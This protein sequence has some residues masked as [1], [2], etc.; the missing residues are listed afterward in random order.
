M[1]QDGLL[2]VMAELLSYL[3]DPI[4]IL[5]RSRVYEPEEYFESLD[6]WQRAWPDA[7]RELRERR[8]QEYKDKIRTLAAGHEIKDRRFY[9]V[10][11]YWQP[12]LRAM[13]AKGR[14]P[15]VHS[16]AGSN[17]TRLAGRPGAMG[18]PCSSSRR[19]EAELR[20]DLGDDQVDAMRAVLARFL[21]RHG[22]LGDAAAGRARALW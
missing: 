8:L 9:I 16:A 1:E 7:K 13:L 22:T 6:A 5:V 4:Q 18:P 15:T 21:E 3:Q 20:R 2:E 12:E 14:S 11:P 10:V 17:T 19:M